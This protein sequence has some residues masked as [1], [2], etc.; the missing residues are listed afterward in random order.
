MIHLRKNTSK[1]VLLRKDKAYGTDN[2]VILV[3][4]AELVNN[5]IEVMPSVITQMKLDFP[6]PADEMEK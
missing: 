1:T 2:A 5:R 6:T 3:N 4:Y